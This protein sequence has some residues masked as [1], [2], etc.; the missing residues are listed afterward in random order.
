[1]SQHQPLPDAIVLRQSLTQPWMF[2]LIVDRYQ[3]LF[4]RKATSLLHSR[5]LAEDAVQE[6]FLRIYKHAQNFAEQEGASFRSWAYRILNNNCL[7]ILERLNQENQKVRR[8]EFIELDAVSAIDTH[9]LGD[10]VSLVKSVLARL[11]Q[12][13]SRLL[14]LYFF[15]EKSYEEIAQVEDIS[16]SAVKSGLHRAKKQFKAIAV[17]LI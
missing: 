2:G 15:E 7:T 12:K 5:D 4:L 6:T 9:H 14:T 10:K 1:M 11:P 13:F 3:A 17:D 16:L 8:V